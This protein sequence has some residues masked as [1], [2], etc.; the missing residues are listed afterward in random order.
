MSEVEKKI[1]EAIEGSDK[2]EAREALLLVLHRLL[3]TFDFL[4]VISMV[5]T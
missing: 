3:G 4:G 5:R 2:K 1:L